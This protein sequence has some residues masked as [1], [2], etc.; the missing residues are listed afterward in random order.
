MSGSGDDG[1]VANINVTPLVDVMLVLLIIFM[2]TAPMLQQ[3]VEVNLPKATTAP[4]KGDSDQVVLSLNKEGEIFIGKGNSV[5]LD[6]LAEKV[7]AIMATRPVEQQK[8]YIQADTELEYGAI[9]QVMGE[10]HK[11]G[12]AQIGLVSDPEANQGKGEANKNSPN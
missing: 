2:V 10:L 8:I 4:L 6:T 7:K 1:P 5:P 3:G 12:I 11:G 9:M